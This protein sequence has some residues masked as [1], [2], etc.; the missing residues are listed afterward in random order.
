MKTIK[1]L[2]SVTLVLIISTGGYLFYKHEYVDTLM[3]SEILGKSDKPMENF[4]TDVFD[5][6]TGLTRHDIKK[7]KERKDYWSKRMDDVTEINDP[8]LQASEM[9]KLYDEMREDEVMSKILDKT[10][11]KTGK[12]A[13]TILDLLN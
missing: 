5:F 13:G 3:L 1:L 7:L 8:S 11:E 2:I 6:D 10:A 4:L 9:A 12:L